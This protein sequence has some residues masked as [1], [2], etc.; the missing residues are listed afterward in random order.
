[1]TGATENKD[2]DSRRI[3][4]LSATRLMNR[5]LAIISQRLLF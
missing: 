1:M 2:F 5:C 3:P 4:E